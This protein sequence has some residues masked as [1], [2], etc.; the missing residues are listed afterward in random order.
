MEDIQ[1]IYSLPSFKISEWKKDKQIQVKSD[2]E[3]EK[4]KNFIEKN[5]IKYFFREGVMP[6]IFDNIKPKPFLLYL[7]GNEKILQQTYKFISIV[8][9][10]KPSSYAIRIIDQLFEILSAYKNIVSVS[11]LANGIDSRVHQLSIKY[12]IP[13]IAVLG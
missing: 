4:I 11:G 1:I 3:Y 6:S 5:N 12:N 2:T 8:G 9:P 10:R 13:T 7:L